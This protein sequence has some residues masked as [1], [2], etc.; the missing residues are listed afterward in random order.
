MAAIA[1]FERRLIGQ[2][3]RDDLAFGRAQEVRLGRPTVLPDQV[4]QRILAERQ[5]GRALQAIADGLNRDGIPTAH[6]G[7]AWWP[8]TVGKVLDLSRPVA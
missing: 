3:T 5:T 8:G 6:G 4:L 7:S 2:R 1:Q